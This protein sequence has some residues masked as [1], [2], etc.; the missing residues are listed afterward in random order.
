MLIIH[1][2]DLKHSSVKMLR[3]ATNFYFSLL[4]YSLELCLSCTNPLMYW[5][6]FWVVT[7]VEVVMMK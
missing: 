4:E 6:V 5:Y 2:E 7:S 1:K 3:T